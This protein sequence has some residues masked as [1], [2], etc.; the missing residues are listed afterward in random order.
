MITVDLDRQDLFQD[1]Y[2][3]DD[4]ILVNLPIVM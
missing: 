4:I 2:E 1:N 3:L